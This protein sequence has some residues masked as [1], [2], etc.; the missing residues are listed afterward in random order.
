MNLSIDQLSKILAAVVPM[1][2][3]AIA[4]FGSRAASRSTLKEHL[5]MLQL[6]PED[7]PIRTKLES[8][9]ENR[10]DQAADAVHFTRA[11]P[12]AIFALLGS[13]GLVYGA[14]QLFAL[15]H[16]W[17]NLAAVLVLLLSSVFMYGIFESLQNKDRRTPAST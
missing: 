10:L 4:L 6:A 15:N 3:A 9:I 12:M 7:S 13:G 11:I 2:V 8:I 17:G 14:I 16:V 1:A 5:E